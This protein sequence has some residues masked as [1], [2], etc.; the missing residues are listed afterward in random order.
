MEYE[1]TTA[2]AGAQEGNNQ[3]LSW[4]LAIASLA[5]V[6]DE[7]G[8]RRETRLADL[9]SQVESLLE[10][11]RRL[12]LPQLATGL[13]RLR[14]LVHREQTTPS[15]DFTRLSR[16]I[17]Y[18]ERI[19]H[20]IE[21]VQTDS[22]MPLALI[23]ADSEPSETLRNALR[24][25]GFGVR[26]F[27]VGLDRLEE[28]PA[29][30]KDASLVIRL[31]SPDMDQEDVLAPIHDLDHQADSCTTIIIGA[32]DSFTQRAAAVKAGVSHFLTEPVDVSRLNTL[33]QSA[34]LADEDKRPIHV[35][36]VDDMA[37]AG[38]Y[39]RKHFDK[40][41]ILFQFESDPETA[42]QKAI[43]MEPDIILLD[44]YMPEIDGMELARIFREHGRLQDVPI[45]FMSTEEGDRARFEAKLQGGDD[46]LNKTIDADDL[47][48]MVRYRAQR[49]REARVAQRTDSLTGLLN[50]M[51]IKDLI[52]S[53]IDR[54][55][56][57]NQAFSIA[58]I[59]LDRFKSVND[60]YGHQAG[61]IVLRQL[62]NMLNTR[63]RRYDGLGR[64]GG[65]EF[66]VVLPNTDET[67][68]AYL[69]NRLRVQ[70]AQTEIDVGDQRMIHCTFSVG[71]A[72]FPARSDTGQLIEAADQNLYLAKEK[73]RNRV[74][75]DQTVGTASDPLDQMP[76]NITA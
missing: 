37:T 45:L 12:Q 34:R 48:R 26:T 73:G 42:Y 23:L 56:R 27:Y 57:Q 16:M 19:V 2:H 47:L 20:N 50:H 44:L 28:T 8:A 40:G 54:A 1:W 51:A 30:C 63:L 33:L 14:H 36:M 35:L 9:M 10:H 71:I 41:N 65:E 17:R 55:G 4:P 61:D 13:D 70:F 32:A 67:T 29:I 49:H 24:R 75:Q 6:L 64:Y 38:M 5:A 68:A 31:V 3:T 60:T 39:W 59:D 62:S 52:E 58:V 21:A 18:I 53:E 15:E 72:S 76:R 7:P 69:L 43:E 66:V 11:A 74:V 25:A 22:A 46:F